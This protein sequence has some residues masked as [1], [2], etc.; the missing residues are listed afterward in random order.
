MR[1]IREICLFNHLSNLDLHSSTLF[2]TFRVSL[3]LVSFLLR[4]PTFLTV[5]IIGTQYHML[6]QDGHHV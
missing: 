4:T 6:P 1:P 2:H 3:I 5:V